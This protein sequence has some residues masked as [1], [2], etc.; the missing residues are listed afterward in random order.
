VCIAL[1]ALIKPKEKT[2]VGNTLGKSVSRTLL[3]PRPFTRPLQPLYLFASSP[4]VL[5]YHSLVVEAFSWFL[6]VFSRGKPLPSYVV[7][8]SDVLVLV[9]VGQNGL[10]FLELSTFALNIN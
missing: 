1:R 10:H 2:F 8:P 7:F 5:S 4:F 3:S 6:G 9:S